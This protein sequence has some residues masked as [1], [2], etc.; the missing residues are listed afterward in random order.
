MIAHE[1]IEFRLGMQRRGMDQVDQMVGIEIV[2]VRNRLGDAA[3][4]DGRGKGI[5]AAGL[6]DAFDLFEVLQE[7]RVAPDMLE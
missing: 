5:D 4:R 6:Q 3:E 2:V 7:I 1:A